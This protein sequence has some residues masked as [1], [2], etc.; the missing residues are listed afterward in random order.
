MLEDFKKHIETHFP[1]LFGKTF[2]LACSG[3]VDSMVL[4]DL[5]DRCNLD[6]VIAHCNFKLRGEASEGDEA[7]VRKVSG[8]IN[9]LFLVTHFDTI[10]YI[11]INKVSLQIAARDLRYSWFAEMMEERGVN[12]LVTAHHADDNL[13]TFI[14]NLSRGTGIAGLTGIPSKTDTI[15]RPL[16]PFSREEI[17]T[18]AH[19]RNLTWREDSSNANTKYLRN[20]IRHEIVPLLK[21]LHPSFLNNFELTR[22]H[23]SDTA[24]L[25]SDY[26]KR[27]QK[28][29]FD[30]EEGIIRIAVSELL[31]LQPRIAYLHALFSEFGF[32]A[33]ED[34]SGLLTAMS[35]KEVRSKTHRLVKD[36]EFLLLTEI[37]P[38]SNEVY[39]IG[40]NE[41]GIE[42]PMHM[43]MIEVEGIGETGPKILYVDKETLK[44]PLTVRKWSE[45]DYFY[46]LG[47]QGK[48]KL[49][50]FFKDEKIDVI[51]K[52]NQL[53]LC[54]GEAIVW[55]IGRRPDN[56]FKVTEKTH[57]IVKFIV[58]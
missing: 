43:Q 2:L 32:S 36:R 51:T 24:S 29:L 8:D 6:F 39:V 54:S 14:I 31:P 56:R 47:M 20:K 1:N 27:L 5:C 16:L 13:E 28:D 46:P 53:L 7:L 48:K 11:N 33:W 41:I 26:A 42:N 25:I 52:H 34:I 15:A 22:A 19:N 45:G 57:K 17:L 12:T 9:K 49:S 50:K 4:V 38:I 35:G 30:E 18:Y 10:G 21:E 58:N 40:E 44:Y 3:G 55:V 37:T 23:L